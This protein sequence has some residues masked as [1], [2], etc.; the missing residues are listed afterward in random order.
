MTNRDTP[1]GRHRKPRPRRVILAAGGL[2][3]AAGALSLVR[4]APETVIGGIGSPDAEPTAGA[5][6]TDT[7]G[8]AAATVE[9]V[10]AVPPAHPVAATTSAVMGGEGTLPRPDVSLAP[11]AVPT[12]SV[13]VP[14]PPTNTPVSGGGRGNRTGIPAATAPAP[15]PPHSAPQPPA[16]TTAAPEPSATPPA[17]DRK[18][19]PPALCLPVVGIC[20]NGT[21]QPLGGR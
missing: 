6:V 9:A 21:T 19:R 3:L 1:R 4:M 20:V 18:P 5:A 13:V 11:S 14:S 17:P 12:R 2:A 7:A 16:T 10:E 8:N 15:V